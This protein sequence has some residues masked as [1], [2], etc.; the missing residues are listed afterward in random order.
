MDTSNPIEPQIEEA[1]QWLRTR[2][3]IFLNIAGSRESAG[4]STGTSPYAEA[5]YVLR[6]L[7]DSAIWR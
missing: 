3:P 1:R 4:A 6:A 2:Q 7:F 5:V